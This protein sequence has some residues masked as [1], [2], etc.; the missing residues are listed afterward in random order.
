MLTR[1]QQK[2]NTI[3]VTPDGSAF[4]SPDGEGRIW[5]SSRDEAWDE[6]GISKI[7]FLRSYP[8]D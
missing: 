8:E 1:Q 3:Y 7:V 4:F 6:T 5:F 2:T